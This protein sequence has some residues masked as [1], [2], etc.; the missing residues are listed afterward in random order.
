LLLSSNATPIDRFD[1]RSSWTVSV[2]GGNPAGL[3][4]QPPPQTSLN[5]WLNYYGVIEALNDEDFDGLNNLMEFAVG[6]D[7]SFSSTHLYPSPTIP[8]DLH[9]LC[10]FT[11]PT[12]AQPGGYGLPGI[13]YRIQVGNDLDGWNPIAEKLATSS[14]WTGSAQVTIGTATAGRIPITVRDPESVNL[15]PRRFMRLTVETVP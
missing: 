14:T 9:M 8:P 5:N 7:V 10:Q 1:N 3:T 2:D 11:L 6:T 13:H 15:H 4:T 12:T